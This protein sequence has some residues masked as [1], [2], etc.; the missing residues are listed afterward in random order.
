M[1]AAVVALAVPG[2]VATASA[3]MPSIRLVGTRVTV[4]VVSLEPTVLTDAVTLAVSLGGSAQFTTHSVVTAEMPEAVR[5]VYESL[6]PESLV[7]DPYPVDMPPE[8]GPA[9]G[10]GAYVSGLAARIGADEWHRSGF[11]GIGVTIGVIDYLDVPLYW[12]ETEHGPRPDADDVHCRS[13]GTDC[14]AMFFDGVDRGG[15]D[16]GAAVVEILREVAPGARLVF[17]RATSLQDYRDL[18]DWFATQDVSVISRSLGSRYD[19]PGD[20]RGDLNE[21]AEYA[22]SRGMLWVNSGGNNGNGKYV[23]Q[24]VELIGLGFVSFGGSRYLPF[25][26]KVSLGGVRWANDWDAGL[27]SRT[28]YD[29][30]LL[31]APK[32]RPELGLPIAV[33]AAK[34]TLGAPPIELIA[35]TFTPGPGEQLYL[36]VKWLLGDIT[37]DVIEVLDYGDGMA[38]GTQAAYSAATPIV[39][40]RSAGVISVGAVDPPGSAVVARYSAQGPSND[41]RVIPSVSAPSGYFTSVLGVFSGTSGA[42]PVVSGLAAVMQSAG[43]PRNPEQLGATIRSNVVDRGPAGPDSMFGAGE[44]RLPPLPGASPGAPPATPPAPGAPVRDTA[45][46]FVPTLPTRLLDTRTESAVGPAAM[47][48]EFG[49]GEV[50]HLAVAGVGG[51]PS[52]KVAAVALNV[53][54]VAGEHPGYVQLLPTGQG[55][56][57]SYSNVNADAGGQVRANFAIVPVGRDGRISIHHRGGGH[58]LLDLVGYFADVDG[59]IAGGRLEQ[60]APQRSLDTRAGPKPA[61]LQPSAPR[62]VPL[63]AGVDWSRASAVVVGITATNVTAPGFVQAFP[64]GRSDLIGTTSTVNLVPGATVANTAIVPVGPGATTIQV[65]AGFGKAPPAGALADVVVDIVGYVTSERAPAATDGRYVA[66][67]PTRVHDSRVRPGAAMDDAVPVVV[68]AAGAVAGLPSTATGIVWN[69]AVVD[70]DR[71]GFARAWADGTTP[72]STSIVNWGPGETR[73]A[74]VIAAATRGRTTFLLDDGS[75]NRPE[76][77]AHLVV[78]VFGY[79]T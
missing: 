32:G 38:T 60:I 78:D 50:R 29:I 30:V 66:I 18:V 8:S 49:P 44:V 58:V 13:T 14:T 3:A 53:T 9:G 51:V 62:A 10:S 21:I 40:S 79:F 23:R 54:M 69:V 72:P 35:G 11:D 65:V 26:G 76:P 59:A 67:V 43:G 31:R 74:A 24:P 39:T 19:D 73:G 16:H 12:N 64:A 41:G 28:D 5:P 2:L 1:L 20:G 7:R 71:A 48:G 33:S 61:P 45:A 55:A 42:A 68:S 36:T 17:G 63:P 77:V 22:V 75:A 15:E 52:S 37:G 4:E 70:T 27:L 34:Q 6:L 47:I 25:S 46:R 56:L 57:G